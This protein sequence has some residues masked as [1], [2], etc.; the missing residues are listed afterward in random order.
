MKYWQGKG[1]YQAEFESITKDL[2]PNAGP[3]DTENG[4]LIRLLGNV[5]YDFGNNGGCNLD[6]S[7]YA[8]WCGMIYVLDKLDYGAPSFS[9]LTNYNP[10][11]MPDTSRGLARLISALDDACDFAVEHITQ[12]KAEK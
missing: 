3:A 6:S 4:E 5:L 12:R 10:K 9:A 2:V 7:K 8:D 11:E 1:K